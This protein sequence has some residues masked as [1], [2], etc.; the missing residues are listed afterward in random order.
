M[1]QHVPEFLTVAAIVIVTPGPDTALTIRNTLA[2]GRAGGVTTALG[3]SLGQ[4]V[5]TLAASAG[6]T[7]LL[8]ASAPLFA[9]IRLM[10]AA[11]L[12]WLGV[13]SLRR[14]ARGRPS[15]GPAVPDD[16]APAPPAASPAALR[17]GFVSNLG[18]PKMA[19]FFTSLLPQ[20][21]T[22][23]AAFGDL[24]ALGLVFCAMT[25]AWLAAYA[26]A[27]GWAGDRL[28]R[29][30]LGRA[31]DAATGLVLAALGLRLAAEQR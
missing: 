8:I 16:H 22:R 2:G 7:A 1:I 15:S 17:Q 9:A 21:T 25:C 3:V 13:Q 19:V 6:L 18:N 26:F 20:F 12:V 14:A 30:G 24:L 4:A 10:G 31:L 5:W 29:T 28:A 27:I 11:Y 23:H